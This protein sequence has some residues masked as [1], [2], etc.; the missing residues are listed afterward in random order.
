MPA[1][2]NPN[3]RRPSAGPRV[4]STTMDLELEGKAA[5]VTGG[6]RG[7]GKAVARQL[8]LEGAA[9]GIAARDQTR[10]DATVDELAAITGAGQTN[11]RLP[12]EGLL[13]AALSQNWYPKRTP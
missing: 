13:P 6:S 3:G 8:A 9:V 2:S 7:I 4:V 1:T 11:R 10:I 12:G 5:I